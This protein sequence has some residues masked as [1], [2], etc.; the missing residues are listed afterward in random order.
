M[1]L[2]VVGYMGIPTGLSMNKSTEHASKSRSNQ[3]PAEQAPFPS[4]LFPKTGTLRVTPNCRALIV[5][6]PTKRNPIFRIW[7]HTVG[8]CRGLHLRRGRTDERPGLFHPPGG[9]LTINFQ[10]CCISMCAYVS[11]YVEEYGTTFA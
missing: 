11:M 2:C 9:P 6:T 8:N 4:A 5:R 7:N 10:G 3:K 1:G